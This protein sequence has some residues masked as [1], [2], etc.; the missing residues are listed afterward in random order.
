MKGF[1]VGDG[2]VVVVVGGGD[3]RKRKMRR[4]KEKSVRVMIRVFK[5]SCVSFFC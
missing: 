3:D 5:I 4:V 1:G 2:G